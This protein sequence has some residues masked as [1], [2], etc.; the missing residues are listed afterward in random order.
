[1]IIQGD[2]MPRS[3]REKSINGTYHVMLRGIN[4]QQI[5]EDNEDYEKF[6]SIL[7]YCKTISKF[8]LFA[9]C[10][11]GN[12][13]HLL[14]KEG[15]EPLELLMKRIAVRF[16]Y[17]YNIK[18]SRVGHLF[19]DR[20]KSEP[21]DDDS[22]CLTVVR[23]IHQNPVKAGLCQKVEEYIYSSFNEFYKESNLLDIGFTLDLI[24]LDD[25][26]EYN[27]LD[28]W[29]ICLDV[30]TTKTVRLTD[31]QAKE[32]IELISGCKNVSEFQ[33]V[34]I[35]KRDKYLSMMRKYGLSIRQISRLT[36]VSYNIARKF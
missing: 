33:Q 17:W 31:E 36:G 8:E 21:V 18:Y 7:S 30:E 13:I 32:Y 3:S 25:F 5:F 19:Q 22:Y 10:L 4:Q 16:V 12:H 27:N 6:L 28:T 2:K 9:Y 15:K 23:Y 29:D 26:A 14:I 20:Y 1:M 24:S 11:M 35:G 34:N